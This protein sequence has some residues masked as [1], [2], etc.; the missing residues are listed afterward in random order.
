[1]PHDAHSLLG[2]RRPTLRSPSAPVPCADGE[3]VGECR[4]VRCQSGGRALVLPASSAAVC[5]FNLELRREFDLHVPHSDVLP[6]PR[7]DA[8]RSHRAA[9]VALEGC[10]ETNT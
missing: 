1:M 2:R 9:V 8:G 3:E 10:H 6:E 5:D 7:R 4:G